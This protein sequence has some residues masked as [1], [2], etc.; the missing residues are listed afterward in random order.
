MSENKKTTEEFEQ[1]DT[2]STYQTGSTQPPKS[3]GGL[4]AFLL[5]LVIFLCGIST[6][7]GL[8]NIKLRWQLNAQ[9][10]DENCPVAFTRTTD[11]FA[12]IDAGPNYFSLGFSG[13]TVTEFW[14]LYEDLPQGIYITE[15]CP[16]TDAAA[17]G[18]EPGDILLRVDQTPITDT[19][20][21]TALLERYRSGDTVDVT[22]FRDGK[23]LSVQL[24]VG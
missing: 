18:V 6:A 10:T 20:A 3:R 15:V 22:L 1:W 12:Q 19:A 23:E 2:Q 17:K 16:L 21:L 4:I 24:K 8:M 11:G 9:A 14:N 5:G 13:E 7:L